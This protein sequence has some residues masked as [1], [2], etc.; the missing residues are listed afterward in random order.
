MEFPRS[1]FAAAAIALAVTAPSARA[2]QIDDPA[3]QN[4]VVSREGPV[5]VF[6]IENTERNLVSVDVMQ[7]LNRALDMAAGDEA[8]G[9]LVVTGTGEVFSDGGGDAGAD[10]LRDMTP[11][12]YAI[13]S[14]DRLERFPMPVIGAINGRAGQGGL[15]L[16]MSTDIRIASDAATFTQL[17]VLVGVIPGFGGIQRLPDLVGRSLA[18]DMMM[19][20]RVLTAEEALSAGLVSRL[21]PQDEVLE[22]AIALATELTEIAPAEPLSVLKTRL[23]DSR[24]ED[25]TY[26]LKKD[27]LAFDAL[28]ASP[29][30]PAR[31]AAFVK[32]LSEAQDQ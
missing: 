2:Q 13:A 15:E 22:D 16:A 32:R 31:V 20:G 23:A 18:T 9:A 17:E 1:M 6:R 5:L 11:S 12:Q 10:V 28:V 27:H 29:E 14:F 21:S 3:I 25:L 7:S 30:F 26:A 4:A 19:T 8:I 24:N